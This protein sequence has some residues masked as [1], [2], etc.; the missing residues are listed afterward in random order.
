VRPDLYP[1]H[2]ELWLRMSGYFD[3]LVPQEA[4]TASVE[5]FARANFRP[6]MIGVHLRRGDFHVY[7]PDV[8]TNTAAAMERIEDHLERE[9]AAGI[10]LATDDG[11]AA[12]AAGLR[13]EGVRDLMRRRFGD[14]VVCTS[15]RSL[16]RAA[17]EAIEDALVDLYLLRRTQAIVGTSVS[18]FSE[19]AAFGRNVPLEMTQGPSDAVVRLERVV[20]RLGLHAPIMLLARRRLGRQP[21]SFWDAWL[22]LRESPGGEQIMRV[23]RRVLPRW[24]R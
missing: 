19:L 6:Q 22:A 13:T 3:A 14:R 7:R 12:D 18:S 4:I 15:P 23:V 9:P 16:D 21:E 17:P 2:A 5:D 10:F 20:R 1:E 8:S 24:R 11:A